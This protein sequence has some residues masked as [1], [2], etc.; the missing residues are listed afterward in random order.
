MLDKLQKLCARYDE[1]EGLLANPEVCADPQK[2]RPLMRER[3]K[4]Q[5]TVE[6]F[7]EYER[8]LRQK[9]E[10]RELVQAGGEADLVELARGEVRAL[11][12]RETVLF[13]EMRLLL[14]DTDANAA[15]DVIVEIRGGVG[16]DE[17]TLFAADLFRMYARWAERGRFKVEVLSSSPSEAGG[18]K[19][20][21]FAV[22]GAGAYERLRYESGGHR[23]QRVP[24]TESQGRVHTSLAT[25]AVLPEVEDI[26]IDLR[27]EDIRLDTFR[28]GGPGGQNVNK[29]SSAVRLTHEPTGLVVICQDESSQ[30][31][32]RAKAMR[33]LRAKLFDLE[34][35]KR[36]SERDRTRKSQ[37]GSGDRS[38]RIR[39]YNYPQN[40][41]TDHRLKENYN[42]ERVIDGDLDALL[43]DL[44][45]LDIEE[46]L[47]ALL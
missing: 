22:A 19:E 44:K 39:T 23:V 47:K 28:A 38:E 29:T 2:S 37:V 42:L 6:K 7:R 31:K 14:V 40:R 10:A 27:D 35:E 34:E 26:E 5:K 30:H 8:V 20:I 43:G 4:L 33:V 18:L 12:E 3:G 13:E 36:R 16:G 25:V 21:I 46:R 24:E 45:R 17:A 11:E 9:E 32:N 15:K 41:V 1:I